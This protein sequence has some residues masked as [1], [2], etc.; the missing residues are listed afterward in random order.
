MGETE[1]C[2]RPSGWEEAQ[3][4]AHPH[5]LRKQN[6]IQQWLAWNRVRNTHLFL[7]K[8]NKITAPHFI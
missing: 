7:Y 1:L 8:T 3:R 6:T 2:L 4:P 5:F